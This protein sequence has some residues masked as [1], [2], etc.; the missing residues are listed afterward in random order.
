MT[1]KNKSDQK[2]NAYAKFSSMGIQMG[3]LIFL[4]VYGGQKLDEKYQTKTPWFTIVGSLLGV[5]A[6]LYVVLKG[7]IK[8]GDK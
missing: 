4:G 1:K 8:M 6:G 3:V 7:V 2:I 5:F